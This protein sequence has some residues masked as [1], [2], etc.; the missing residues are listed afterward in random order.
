[1]SQHEHPEQS[2][3]PQRWWIYYI[4]AGDYEAYPERPAGAPG[5]TEVMPVSNYQELL[6]S[7]VDAGKKVMRAEARVRSLPVSPR[8]LIALEELEQAAD[9]LVAAVGEK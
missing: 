1:M 6:A 4:G 9:A 8:I 3:E 7:V 5:G 2:S